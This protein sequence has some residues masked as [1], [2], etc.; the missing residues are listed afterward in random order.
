M[1]KT[2]EWWNK[3]D[4]KGKAS[5]IVSMFLLAISILCLF[6]LIFCRQLFGDKVGDSILGEGVEN[7]FVAI[8]NGIVYS[9][10]KILVTFITI[11]LTIIITT[12][13]N[14]IVRLCTRTGK[15][16]KTVGSLIRS[17]VK[18]IAVIVDICI[19]LSTWGVNVTSIIAGLGVLT[20]II[21]LGC[22]S[23]I[24]DVISGL[25]M[26]FD[27]YFDVGDMVIIDGFRGYVTQIGLRSVKIDDKLG[28][29]KSINNSSITSCVNLSRED[30][31]VAMEIDISY[32]EDPRKVEAILLKELPAL[33]DKIP[34]AIVPPAYVGMSNFHD[35][36]ISYKISATCK[37]PY[38]FQLE[39]DLRRELYLIMLNNNI[40]V[41]YTYINVVDA[42]S[43]AKPEATVNEKE[44]AEAFE[45]SVRKPKTER[46]KRSVFQRV[47]DVYTETVEET[48]NDLK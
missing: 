33:K 7:G 3:K 25:F 47:K 48:K 9:G 12:I 4:K 17:L 45:K 2:A 27:D 13:I 15:K 38:R 28:N 40:E 26:V 29:I 30:N 24:Q 32:N 6:G 35:S 31:T 1:S 11:F 36:G 18:Y 16:T 41:P 23:L 34:Q 5:F 22:Q 37:T 21:G 20:L 19:I 10:S 42:N 39:R 46:K 8:G 43:V 44:A 14:F